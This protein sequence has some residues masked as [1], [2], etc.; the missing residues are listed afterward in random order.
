[1]DFAAIAGAYEGIK[2]TKDILKSAFDAKVDAEAKAKIV[3]AQSRLGDIQDT[4]F[5][6]REQM[7]A[8]QEER[9]TLKRQ[10]DDTNAWSSRV[11][12]YEL[13]NTPGGAVVL[14]S[15]GALKHFACPSCVNKREIH[16]LQNNRTLSGKYRCTGCGS[17]FPI[18]PRQSPPTVIP[19][20]IDSPW[21]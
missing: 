8:L 7:F 2:A 9:N 17:E 3:E 16:I 4:L 14:Q 6:M 1:M 12:E 13:T 15:K 11:A 19:M 20:P 21:R 5:S 18:E 10:L